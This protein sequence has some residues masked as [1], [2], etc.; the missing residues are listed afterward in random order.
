MADWGSWSIW[1][2]EAPA[3]PS[4]DAPPTEPEAVAADAEEDDLYGEMDIGTSLRR[5]GSSTHG[6][7]ASGSLGSRRRPPRAGTFDEEPAA[8]E[9]AAPAQDPLVDPDDAADVDAAVANDDASQGKA[10][11]DNA[12]AAATAAAA[13]AMSHPPPKKPA[14]VLPMPIHA[15]LLAHITGWAFGCTPAAVGFGG[16]RRSTRV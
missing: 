13:A 11:G 8:K 16:C 14:G 1:L 10:A 6:S 2:A 12:A 15:T 3:Q 7:S 9:A 4:A 5:N